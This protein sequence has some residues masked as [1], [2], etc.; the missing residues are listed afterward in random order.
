MNGPKFYGLLTSEQQRFAIGDGMS[1][2]YGSPISYTG[3]TPY[4]KGA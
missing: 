1:D 3:E 2:G 4:E